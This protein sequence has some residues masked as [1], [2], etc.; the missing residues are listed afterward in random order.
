MCVALVIT[1]A[2][3]LGQNKGKHF[4][5]LR[6]LFYRCISAHLNAPALAHEL[7]SKDTYKIAVMYQHF[8][9]KT[10]LPEAQ[11]GVSVHQNYCMFKSH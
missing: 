2:E 5:N 1:D 10:I 8:Q 7:V 3:N 6:F 11:E 9:L 4:E